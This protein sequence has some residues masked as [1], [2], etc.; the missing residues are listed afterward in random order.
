MIDLIKRLLARS[1]A[2][3]G[4]VREEGYDLRVAASALLLEMARIDGEFSA[5]EQATILRLLGERFDLSN[6][7]A[8]EL[9]NAATEAEKQSVDLWP[10][11][12]RINQDFSDAEK[13]RV[14]EMIW[15]IAYIDGHLDQHEDYLVHKL[16]NLLRLSHRQLIE[17]KLKVTRRPPGA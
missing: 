11:A 6:E 7:Q 2:A 9:L 17:A 1:A 5:E 3:D 15:E 10:F 16:A 8:A 12:R 4:E 13:E 14:I